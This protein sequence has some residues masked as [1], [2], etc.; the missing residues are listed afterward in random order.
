M[1]VAAAVIG[2]LGALA[3]AV[4]GLALFAGVI[5]LGLRG[6]TGFNSFVLLWAGL[7]G[8]TATI[9]VAGM[10]GAGFTIAGRLRAAALLMLVGAAGVAVAAVAYDLLLPIAMGPAFEPY[11]SPGARWYAS[12]LFPVPPLLVGA[13]LAFFARNRAEPR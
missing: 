13:A 2:G 10:A 9:S 12:N 3:G 8:G 4:K 5:I 7:E 11:N 1:R 6:A